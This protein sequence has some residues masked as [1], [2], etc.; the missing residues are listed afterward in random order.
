MFITAYQTLACRSYDLREIEKSLRLAK[1][2]NTL[3][4]VKTP[5]RDLRVID[6]YAVIPGNNDV[7]AFTHPFLIEFDGKPTLVI[8]HRSYV[9]QSGGSTVALTVTNLADYKFQT[10][11]VLFNLHW[12]TNPEALLNLGELGPVVF[13]RWLSESI[14]R[15][16]GLGPEEQAKVMTVSLF[17]WHSLFRNGE[18]WEEK[19]K[20]RILTKLN[21]ISAIPTSLSMAIVDQITVMTGIDSY[22][23]TL[24]AVVNSVRLENLN[25]PLLFSMLGGSWFGL[26]AKETVA[27][28]LEHPPTFCAIL[29]SAL[30]SRSYQKSGLGQLVKDLDRKDRGS[31]FSKNC[32][33][34]FKPHLD[35]EGGKL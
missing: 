18:E 10:T 30:E 26:N 23:E 27:V 33:G 35:I 12:L 17:Y 20:L 25:T 7:P 14:V 6:A 1:I 29:L 19:E 3:A 32:Y 34:I 21:Q 31:Q 9:R 5:D 22:I 8:D 4:A 11:R 24:K 13:C 16:L 28:A 15:R 2:E